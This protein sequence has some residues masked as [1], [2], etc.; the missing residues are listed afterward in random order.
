[1]TEKEIAPE[2]KIT[3]IRNGTVIDHI[4]AG[5]ALSVLRILGITGREGF[6]VSIAM[7]VPS[8]KLGK[9]DIVKVE[10]RELKAEEVNKIALIAPRATINII[11]DYAVVKKIR[12]NLPEEIEDIVKCRNPTCITNSPREPIKPK[13]KVIS[14]EPVKLRC[15]YCNTTIEIGDIIKQLT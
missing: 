2:L 3:P 8:K 6:V 4:T 13:F 12:V 14:R 10:G 1:M 5:Y 15:M 9:K 7:N 11:K